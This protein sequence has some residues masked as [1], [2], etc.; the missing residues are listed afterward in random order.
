MA[1]T[2]AAAGALEVL[3]FMEVLGKSTRPLVVV[4]PLVALPLVLPPVVLPLVVLPLVALPLVALPAPEP[5]AV[6]A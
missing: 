4:V 3:G 1:C 5:A 6:A 2:T